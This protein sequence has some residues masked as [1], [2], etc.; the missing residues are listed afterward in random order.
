METAMHALWQDVRYATRKLLRQPGFTLAALLTLALGMSA[1]AV[2]FTIVNALLLRPPAGVAS[3]D[4]LVRLYTA[5]YSSGRYGASS[6]AD[7]KDF[8]GAADVFTDVAAYQ[9]SATMSGEVADPKRIGIELVSPNYFDVLGVPLVGRG[10]S[11][12][13]AATG[14]AVAVVSHDY[15]RVHMGARPDALGA[16]ILLN[17]RPL[18]VIGVG[19]E[20]FRGSVRGMSVDA[21]IPASTGGTIGLGSENLSSRGDRGYAVIARMRPGVSIDRAQR[22]MNVLAAQLFQAYPAEWS[23]ISGAGRTLTV[24]PERASRIPMQ[25]SKP[26]YGMT[27]L[28]AGIAVLVL[29]TCCANVA[30][31]MIARA[32]ALVREIGIRLSMGASRGRIARLLMVESVVLSVTAAVIGLFTATWIIDALMLL[33]PRLPVPISLDVSIDVRVI[34]FTGLIALATAV[35]VGATPAIRAS[36]SD[37]TTVMKGALSQV[38]VGRTRFSM[39]SVLV[40]AQ[41]AAS[42][43][44][45][46][47][48][49]VF[50]RSMRGAYNADLGF[51]TRST[52]ILD[53]ATEPGYEPA[54]EEGSRVA[55]AAV[56]ALAGMPGVT[57]ATW[58]NDPPLGLSGSRRS[59]TIEGYQRA[60]GEDMEFHFGVVGPDYLRT[61]GIP[62]RRGRD[63]AAGDRTGAPPVVVVNEAFAN[64]FWPGQNAIGRRISVDGGVTMASV[65]GVTANASLNSIGE[66]AKPYVYIPDL[67]FGW[68]GT[69]LVVRGDALSTT[70]LDAMKERLETLSPRW[71]VER[72]RPMAAQ[73]AAAILPQRIAGSVLTLFG[74]V[75]LLLACIGLYGVI[76]YAV[77]QRTH[78]F[79]IRFA[80][81]ATGRDILALMMGQG[82]R[83]VA[84]GTVVGITLSLL[85]TSAMRPLLLGMQ[86]LDPVSFLIAPVLLACVAMMASLLPAR[87]AARHDPLEALRSD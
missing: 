68:W 67:Q 61:M 27:A 53:L 44:L 74:G 23:H 34:A 77:A 31:L 3:P 26:V 52:A 6:Y 41:V 10:F 42:V 17:G 22:R 79:G 59:M 63:L 7:L 58:A 56:T 78:E 86:P 55:L 9:P 54:S 50:T 24:R 30:G 36:R 4:A 84:I 75:A 35:L 83:V 32:S 49:L 37:L 57:A 62:L 20:A 39:R 8:A 45:L 80:L 51:D 87:R 43:M 73:V 28:L 12:G 65:V 40:A 16:T 33:A 2:L 66:E 14:A 85:A 71:K 69:T 21:W 81:G 38:S 1:N 64:R 46:V 19:P 15:W 5:D 72:V 47:A 29:L 25:L 60:K 13:E 48:A 76:A 11:A 70:A 18:S 82:M